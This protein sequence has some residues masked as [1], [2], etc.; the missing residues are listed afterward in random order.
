MPVPIAAA[1]AAAGAAASAA[2]YLNAKY[3]IAHDLRGELLA[4]VAAAYVAMRSYKK[5]LLNHHVLEEQAARQPDHPFLIFNA[6]GGD[7]RREWTYAEFLHDVRRVA[8]WLKDDLGVAVSEIVALDGENSPEYMLLWFALDAIGA[9]PSFINCNLTSNALVHCVTLCK[10]R[11]LL[12]D[13][14]TKPLVEPHEAELQQS[15]IR[16]LYYTPTLLTTLTT[17]STPIPALLTSPLTP[18]SLRALI[19]TSGTTGHPKA[20]QI[21]TLRDLL[22]GHMVAHALHLTPSS[23][24]YTCMPL[25]HIAAHSLCTLALLHGGGTVVLARRFSHRTFWPDVRAARANAMQYVGELCRYLMNAPADPVGDRMHE[26]RLAWG[27]GMRPDVWEGFRERFGVGEVA[28][29]YGATDGLAGS[30]NVNRG[31]FTRGALALRGRVWRWRNGGRSAIVRV[32]A[33]GEVVRGEKGWAVVC[34]DGEAGEWLQRMDRRMPDDGFAGY[35]GNPEAGRKRKLEG[36]FEEGDLWFRT[37][38]ML[39]LDSEGRLFFVDRLGDTFRWKAENVSTNE[40]ADVVGAFAQV[41]E[42]NVYGVAV[43]HADGR[44]GATAITFVDGVTGADG[45]DFKGLA[46]HAVRSLPRYAVPVFVRVTPK[47]DYTGTLKMQKGRLKEEGIEVGKVEESGDQLY[48]LPP[49]GDCYVRFRDE[50][51]ARI[52]SGEVKL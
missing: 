43:P 28:E 39:R 31:V 36:V 35:F 17:P 21:S 48:W 11:Y 50:D 42:A 40:V 52:K 9:V 33:E 49:G 32:D 51:Y 18:H 30:V 3:H 19:Y 15:N 13:V 24:M 20:T 6:A 5:R 22:T 47:L 46:D 4:P 1:A 45:F 41:A 37:G 10:C 7:N 8:N 29:L 34:E 23:R 26:V 14:E 27:N 12:C 2:A 25:Y 16:T 44:C 38:D